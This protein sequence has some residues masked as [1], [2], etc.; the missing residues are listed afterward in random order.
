MGISTWLNAYQPA[1]IKTDF[2]P[3]GILSFLSWLSSFKPRR[4]NPWQA[5]LGKDCNRS[6]F[7]LSLPYSL[8]MANSL[9]N[10]NS[11]EWFFF[12]LKKNKIS[13]WKGYLFW[14]TVTTLWLRHFK[15][16]LSLAILL[17]RSASLGHWG[18]QAYIFQR[19]SFSCIKPLH[20]IPTIWFSKVSLL[21]SNHIIWD[22]W[23]CLIN[24]FF[25]YLKNKENNNSITN[26][27]YRRCSA[28]MGSERML[29]DFSSL[30]LFLQF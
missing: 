15:L 11:E 29:H 19:N 9:L 12:F 21:H 1:S 16:M 8:E 6:Y 24:S 18:S 14:E 25:S 4:N 26:K 28:S 22:K 27:H 2:I 13:G 20:Q 5:L 3:K 7:I 23:Q 17:S 30:S 10:R